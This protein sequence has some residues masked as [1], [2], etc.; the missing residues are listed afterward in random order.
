MNEEE[1][2]DD[3][4]HKEGR[5]EIHRFATITENENEREIFTNISSTIQFII[6][7]LKYSIGKCET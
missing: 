7:G 6:S 1:D 4:V 5:F 3:G 2:D